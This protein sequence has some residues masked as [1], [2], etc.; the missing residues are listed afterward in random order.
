[1]PQKTFHFRSRKPGNSHGALSARIRE[2]EQR[3]LKYGHMLLYLGFH[4][5]STEFFSLLMCSYSW[6]VR[7]LFRHNS[8][9]K[10]LYTPLEV[11][12]LPMK[13]PLTNSGFQKKKKTSWVFFFACQY[14][15]GGLLAQ[16]SGS[17]GTVAV[18]WHKETFRCSK[19]DL[20]ERWPCHRDI[21]GFWQVEPCSVPGAIKRSDSL[22]KACV[23]ALQEKTG[24]KFFPSSTDT[25]LV[26]SEESHLA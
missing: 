14:M 8:D 18:L 16:L 23:W 26:D 2:K 6:M 22:F 10:N 11:M 20:Q 25:S 4:C 21:Y 24:S 13:S 12:G 3:Q 19:K 9:D 1:M 5:G 17:Q 15:G 7:D